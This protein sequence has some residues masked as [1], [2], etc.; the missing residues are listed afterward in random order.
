MCF[1]YIVEKAGEALDGFLDVCVRTIF[2]HSLKAGVCP[3][4]EVLIGNPPKMVRG[5]KLRD[6][7]QLCFLRGCFGYVSQKM[8]HY[9]RDDRRIQERAEICLAD[10]EEK[11]SE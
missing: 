9:H 2:H 10:A 4:G 8:K 7:L 1:T 3:G 6:H 5:Q 11:F